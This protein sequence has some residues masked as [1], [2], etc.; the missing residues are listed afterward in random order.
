MA[1]KRNDE[2]NQPELPKR[3]TKPVEPPSVS[4]PANGAANGNGETHIKVEDV[5][6][7]VV[8][9]PFVPSARELELHKR[10]D[11]NFLQYASYVIR[12]R[13][14]PNLEDGL[15]PVQRRI[16]WALKRM[17]DGRL[18]KV[19]TVSGEAMKYHPHGQ[20]AIDD[21][22]VVL[23]N[24]RY[25]IEGQGNYG[26]IY[27]G[28]PAAASRYI[29][30]RLTDLAR[31][32][33]FNDELTDFVPSYDGRNQEPVALPSK[34]PLTLMLG[35]EGIAVGLSC[36]ILPHNF[37]EL[38]EGQIAILKGENFRLIP[39]FQTGGLMDAREYND[40]R[41]SIKVRAKIK[42]KDE[43][44][45]V[46]SEIPPST[47]TESL[48]ASIEAAVD[49]GKLKVRS[50]HDYTAEKPEIELKTPPGVTADQLIN[51][52][53]AFTDCEIS[54]TSRITVIKDNRPVE[55]SASEVLRANTEQ[56]V[57]LYKRELE[58]KER[59]LNDE[60][61]FRTLERIFIE[62][63]IYK[64]IEQCKTN[65][66][67]I[68]AVY[69]GFKPFEKELLREITNEDVD[70]LLQVRI[71]RI[72]LFDINKHREELERLKAELAETRKSLKGLTKYVIGR[73]QALIDTYKEQYPRLTKSSRYDE[74]E[75]KEVAFKAFKVSYDREKGY[76]GYKA[77]GEE[78]RIDCT[79]YDKLL[80]VFKDGHYKMVELP[81]KL[82]VGP[83]LVYCGLPERDRVFTLAYTN[84]EA[85][86]LKRFTFGGM[87]LDREYFCIPEK[88]RILF[89]EENTPTQLYIKYKAVPHQKVSQ[90]TC[91]PGELSVKGA[92][93]RGNQISIKDV[94]S[95]NTKPPR[96]WDETAATTELKFA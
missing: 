50:I 27:T 87:I 11:T 69:D 20:A 22:I 29:E 45:V 17:D 59:K 72:S 68:K 1:A 74:V 62:E 86:Y 79:R 42:S 73:I 95:V 94:Q 15:K 91:K 71:R 64:K 46:I 53:Y 63:R 36:R 92:K 6:A 38:L 13:A 33:I 57:E 70:R 10:V 31:K 61:H 39:D 90:Q 56:A 3:A 89:F 84:R 35:A 82:F 80:L 52:L 25:L 65:E 55:M 14:I 96:N 75:A 41:G 21:A 24:K 77:G 5:P 40:G 76:I 34:L 49:K 43:N 47:T 28:D 2:S 12:D 26:N 88:S 9:R 58:V 60:L 44:T 18:I 37:I 16:L 67:V 4:N 48:I 54:I 66:A 30:C 8:H 93:S 83:D 32:E 85:S 7:E 19:A 23:A 51:A 81:E 78:F